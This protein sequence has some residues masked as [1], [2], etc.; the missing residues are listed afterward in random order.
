MEFNHQNADW[1]RNM[2]MQP[3]KTREVTPNKKMIKPITNIYNIYEEYI[4][5]QTIKS[6]QQKWESINN[7]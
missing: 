7:M 5:I 6:C 3:I 2:F 4:S 1:T